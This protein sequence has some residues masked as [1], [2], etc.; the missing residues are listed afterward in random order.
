MFRKLMSKDRYAIIGFMRV[1]HRNKSRLFKYWLPALLRKTSI[2]FFT[3]VML[4]LFLY[5]LGSF[6]EFTDSTQVFLLNFLNMIMVLC[7]FSSFFSAISY[8]YISP[9]RKKNV[10]FKI[11][12]SLVIFSFTIFFYILINFLMV[13]F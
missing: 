5:I 1:L 12:L 11:I 9:F 13:W 8:I 2:F 3:N 7:I 10:I 6:Q 4:I